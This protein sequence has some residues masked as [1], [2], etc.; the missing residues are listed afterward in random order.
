[1]VVSINEWLLRSWNRT[2]KIDNWIF[3]FIWLEKFHMATRNCTVPLQMF[4]CVWGGGRL[5]GSFYNTFDKCNVILMFHVWYS[6]NIVERHEDLCMYICMFAYM[7]ACLVEERISLEGK[8][9]YKQK[10]IFL[11]HSRKKSTKHVYIVQ[12]TKTCSWN[13]ID[14]ESS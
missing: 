13:C 12:N 5:L 4:L 7:C 6:L 1:M 10:H 14:C 9:G 3:H 11:T 8:C 2:C